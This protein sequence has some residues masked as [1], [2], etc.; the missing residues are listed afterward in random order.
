M[1]AIRMYTTL[2]CGDCR[3]ARQFLKKRS[4]PY[5]DINIDADRDGEA[6]VLKANNGRGK[7]PTFDI[8]GRVFSCSP[9]DGERF[10]L[11]LA[12]Q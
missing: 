12:V 4:I 3:Q 5:T 11:E 8:D 2:W 10:K 7:V 1:A 6:F 9:F